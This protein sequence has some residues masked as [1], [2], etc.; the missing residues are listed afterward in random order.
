MYQ[1]SD[2]G[3][4][5]RRVAPIGVVSEPVLLSQV[6]GLTSVAFLLTAVA[7][8]FSQGIGHG[9][10]T[11]AMIVG[12]FLIFP[13]SRSRENTGLGILLFYLFALC[14]GVA[15]SPLLTYYA[16]TIGPE[17]IVQAA[18]TTGVGMAV[19]GLVVYATGFDYRRLSGIAFGALL[20]LVI[21]GVLSLFVTIVHPQVFA[22]ATLA[23]FSLLLLID[24]RRI[25]VGGDGSTA[26]ALALAIY[27][28]GLNIFLALLQ[29]FG[30]RSRDD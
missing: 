15:I 20:G 29:L 10:A 17:V 30:I 5:M 27:L 28:D 25:R 4:G 11:I 13:L 19:L 7:S 12:F 18:A 21:I 8:Y 3:Y 14:E 23:I 24:F 26:V 2:N 9:F 1:R 6:L 22:W 16:R